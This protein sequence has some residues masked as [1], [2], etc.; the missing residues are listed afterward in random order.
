VNAAFGHRHILT[1]GSAEATDDNYIAVWTNILKEKANKSDP[2]RLGKHKS[3]CLL[4]TL[5]SARWMER[6]CN[7]KGV[8]TVNQGCCVSFG[9]WNLDS[10]VEKRGEWTSYRQDLG[11]PKCPS[12]CPAQMGSLGS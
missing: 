4:L 10:F 7:F 11:V 3:L 8:Q 12:Y 9:K 2:K 5:Q 1:K 6:E